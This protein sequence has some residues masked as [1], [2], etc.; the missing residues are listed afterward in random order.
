VSL[1]ATD[2]N[3]REIVNYEE[4][5]P[6]GIPGSMNFGQFV[7]VNVVSAVPHVD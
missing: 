4:Y 2:S 7:Q 6:D 1:H 3:E 5:A